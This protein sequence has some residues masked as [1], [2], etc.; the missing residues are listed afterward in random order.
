MKAI[1]AVNALDGFGDGDTMPWPRNSLDLN[2]FKEYTT[3]RTVIMGSGTWN[4]NIPRPLPNRRNIVL[5]K[6]LADDRCEVYGNITSLLMNLSQSE[7]VY[8][9]GGAKVLWTLRQYVHEVYLTRF[10][11][12]QRST[13]TLNTQEY[14]AGFERVSSQDHGDHVFEIYRRT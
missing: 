9:I 8:V 11:T 3:G 6:T 14:L 12:S 13:V 2:R 5:S 4:S 10:F 7:D 1:F